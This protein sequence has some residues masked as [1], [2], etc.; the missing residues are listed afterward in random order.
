MVKLRG[1]RIE[2]AALEHMI[3]R[4]TDVQ[5]AVVVVQHHIPHQQQREIRQ[6]L[7][8]LLEVGKPVV[9]SEVKWLPKMQSSDDFKSIVQN[10][11]I[12]A[13][14][15]FPPYMVPSSYLALECFPKTTSGKLDRRAL[16][17]FAN[18]L[19]IHA[20]LAIDEKSAVLEPDTLE[21][22]T[23]QWI[24]SEV[25]AVPR[26]RIGKNSHF[27]RLG[28]DSLSTIRLVAALRQ[29]EV[30]LT[31][32]QIVA[33]PILEIQATIVSTKRSSTTLAS[34]GTGPPPF[35]LLRIDNERRQSLLAY[36]SNTLKVIL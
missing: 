17:V 30:S 15:T 29:T 11:A 3:F 33:N 27:F 25:L 1:Q 20:F 10:A 16:Q 24:R 22:I 23:L 2:V 8:C 26:T 36:I 18:S 7:V 31:V 5:V 34:T 32:Q 6:H 13:E 14:S 4:A 21:E 12:A 35:S 9:Q 19:P 28:G